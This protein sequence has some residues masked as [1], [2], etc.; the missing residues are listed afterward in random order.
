MNNAKSL[1]PLLICAFL[2]VFA[3]NAANSKTPDLEKNKELLDELYQM[4]YES[5]IGNKDGNLVIFDFFDN[6]CGDCKDIA[7]TLEKL[8]GNNKDLRVIFIDYPI[9]KGTSVYAALVCMQALQ[10]GK[11]HLL[12]D[13]F[14]SNVGKMK[15]QDEVNS[16]AQKAGVDVSNIEDNDALKSKILHN[17]ETGHKLAITNV[18]TLFIGYANAPHSTTVIVEPKADELEVLVNKYLKEQT[19]K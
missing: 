12:H 4:Q 18:P 5:Y 13:A 17:L 16:I 6:N 7:P 1:L 14:I 11:Y 15:T 19:T 8:A 3:L 2:S 10:E 9:L